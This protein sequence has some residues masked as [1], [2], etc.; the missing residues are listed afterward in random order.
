MIT[1]FHITR[2][3]LAIGA[4]LM[5]FGGRLSLAADVVITPSAGNGVVIT[6][7]AGNAERLRVQESGEVR[8]CS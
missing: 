3:V 7:S 8:L 5:P 1:W 4:A 6:D 2:L